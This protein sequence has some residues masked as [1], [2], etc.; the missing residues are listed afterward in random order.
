MG[1]LAA[2]AIA[3]G[4]LAEGAGG[5]GGAASSG[6]G[7]SGGVGG[8]GA[9]GTGGGG[10]TGSGP[11]DGSVRDAAGIDVALP[12]LDA[13]LASLDAAPPGLAGFAFIVND[14]VQHPMSCTGAQWEFAPYPGTSAGACAGMKPGGSCPGIKSVVLVNTGAFD[15]AYIAGPWWSGSNYA[16]GGSPG[17]DFGTGVLA[18]GAYADITKFYNAGDV[19]IVGSAAPFWSAD[20]SYAGDEGTIP[21]PMGVAGSGGAT[22]MYIAEIEVFTS[23]SMTFKNW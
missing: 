4:G 2:S 23:C 14:V 17:G 1:V 13:A 11:E 20:A 12:P 9:A 10:T 18:P 5:G 8:G 15:L 21:W 22:T 16:P 6:S 3:C 19:A 7:G